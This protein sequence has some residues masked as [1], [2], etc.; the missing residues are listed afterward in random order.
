MNKH[1]AH[2]SLHWLS[3]SKVPMPPLSPSQHPPNHAGPCFFSLPMPPPSSS[4]HSP[5]HAGPGPCFFFPFDGSLHVLDC[6]NIGDRE[7]MLKKFESEHHLLKL[8]LQGAG[9]DCA[10]VPVTEVTKMPPHIALKCL[11]ITKMPPR[12]PTGRCVLGDLE[13][14]CRVFIFK[15]TGVQPHLSVG[16]T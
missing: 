12:Y 2:R 7:S 14:V 9:S 15:D 4:Q 1:K 10:E 3:C 16:L 8:C 5:N 6:F 11:L 13:C